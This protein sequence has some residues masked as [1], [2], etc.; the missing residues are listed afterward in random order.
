VAFPT[1]NL[2]LNATGKEAEK[3]LD[4]KTGVQYMESFKPF[5]GR[6]IDHAEE[7]VLEL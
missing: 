6:S 5:S 7:P 1:R 3:G 2:S 4:S